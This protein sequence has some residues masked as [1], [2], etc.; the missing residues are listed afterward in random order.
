MVVNTQLILQIFFV[1]CETIK[2]T[3]ERT[4]VY[5]VPVFYQLIGVPL[6]EAVGTQ[7]PLPAAEDTKIVLSWADKPVD[8]NIYIQGFR[9]GK[10]ACLV[11]Y[12]QKC[13]C[14]SVCLHLGT[15][16]QGGIQTFCRLQI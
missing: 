6:K 11:Y 9:D 15:P 1:C 10:D 12:N 2:G 13:G 7:Y 8:L 14:P 3:L 16:Q 4:K 5:K